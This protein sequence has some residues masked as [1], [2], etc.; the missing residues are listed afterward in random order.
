MK[1]P[2]W[3]TKEL[4]LVNPKYFA[5]YSDKRGKYYIR[6]WNGAYPRPRTWRTDSTPICQVPYP[7]L[8]QRIIDTLR[9]GLYWA[10]KAKELAMQVDKHNDDIVEQEDR[11][12]TYINRYMAKR[13]Y[14]YYREKTLDLGNPNLA[15]KAVGLGEV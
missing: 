15:P 5:I 10:R 7:M 8:D 3:F 1:E 4:G 13:I 6:K 14:E 11:E 12:Q 9:K 2:A